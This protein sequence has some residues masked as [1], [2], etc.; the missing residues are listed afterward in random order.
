MKGT[1]VVDNY[2]PIC[3]DAWSKVLKTI[4]ATLTGGP[5]PRAFGVGILMLIPKDTPGQ[6]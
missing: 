2:N 1:K 5:V 6:Y 3:A 4:Q